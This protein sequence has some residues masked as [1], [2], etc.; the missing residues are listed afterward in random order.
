MNMRPNAQDSIQRSA[1]RM[2]SMSESSSRE[3]DDATGRLLEFGHMYTKVAAFAHGFQNCAGQGTPAQPEQS[4][5]QE[6]QRVFSYCPIIDFIETID[7]GR[8][9]RCAQSCSTV[10]SFWAERWILTGFLKGRPKPGNSISMTSPSPSA[11]PSPKLK[12]SAPKK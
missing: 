1:A 12:A 8:N 2:N 4:T 3:A 9:K 11:I 7:I 10:T 5:F 6:A